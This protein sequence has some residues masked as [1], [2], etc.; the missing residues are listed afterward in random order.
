[1]MHTD[2][3]YCDHGREILDE[4]AET[5]AK[6]KKSKATVLVIYSS[7]TVEKE[8]ELIMTMMSE[9]NSYDEI[10]PLSPDFTCI[11]GSSSAWL[12]SEVK[13]ATTVLCVCNKEFQDEWEGQSRPSL[14]FNL[15]KSLKHL[16]LA[17]VQSQDENLFKYAVVL[18]N[19][20][21]RQYIPTKYLQSESRSFTMEETKDIA[22]YVLKTP[23]CEL[24]NEST[25]DIPDSSA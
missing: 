16:I 12:E 9:L 23:H 25:I 19:P 6:D 13:K 14:Q 17:T 20:S 7:N 8:R 4:K 5:S 15:V 11:Q 21:H 10:E 3:S 18:L 2:G 22:H 1:M 24:S